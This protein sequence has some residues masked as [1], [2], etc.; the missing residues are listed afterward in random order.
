MLT[1]SLSSLPPP[2]LLRKANLTEDT[3][4]VC[5][6]AHIAVSIVKS[7]EV[8]FLKFG[9]CLP[10]VKSDELHT[11]GGGGELLH[12]AKMTKDTSEFY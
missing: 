12:K 9:H 3:K 11:W 7:N 6:E 8:E 5:R 2:R 4:A 1:A 10:H